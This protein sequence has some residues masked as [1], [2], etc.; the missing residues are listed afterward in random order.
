MLTRTVPRSRELALADA[1]AAAEAEAFANGEIPEG[2]DP[3]DELEHDLD[4]DVPNAEEEG[5][6]VDDDEIDDE[7]EDNLDEQALADMNDEGEGDYAEQPDLDDDVPEAGSY[8]HTDTEVEDSSSVDEPLGA[9]VGDRRIAFETRQDAVER[10][11][12]LGTG[13]GSGVLGSSVFGSSP[14]VQMSYQGRRGSGGGRG[15]GREN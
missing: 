11:M 8:Q 12:R 4:N 15:R 10:S 2:L 9:G 5:G 7:D 14:V 6:W 3:E 13:G 1:Q